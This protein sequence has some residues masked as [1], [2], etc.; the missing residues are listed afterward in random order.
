MSFYQKA[1]ELAGMGF[2]VFPL[3]SNSKLPLIKDF[4]N[5]ATRD[6][7][8]IKA[9]WVDPVLETERDYNVGIS[10]SKFGDN[11]TLIVIDVDNKGDKKGDDSLLA[12]EL[13]GKDV[14]PTLTQF[15]PTGGIHFIYRHFEPVKQGVNVLGN[16]IDIRAKGGFIVAAGSE[17]EA[18]KYKMMSGPV[19]QAPKWLVSACGKP[20]EKTTIDAEFTV[21]QEAAVGRAR[22]YLQNAAPVEQGQRNHS[23]YVMACKLKDFGVNHDKCLG[24]M[25]EHWKCEPPLDGEELE[26]VVSSAYTYG[27]EAVGS[28]APEAQFAPVLAAETL[29]AVQE[30]SYLERMNQE[31]ALV[32]MEG[33]HFIL[34]ETVDEKGRQKRS[35]LTEPTFKRKFSPN[36]VQGRGTYATEWLDWSRRREYRGVCF[37]PEREARNDYYN[38]WRGFTVTPLPYA[39]GDEVQ[40]KGFDSFI[41][42]ARNNICQ[43]DEALFQWLIGYF[44]HMV[45]RPYERPL[46][47]IVFRGGKG[48]GKNALVDRVGA[49]L[50]SGHYLVAHDGRYL[51]SNFNAHFDSCLCLV[52]DEAFWSG[53][54]NAEGKLKGLTTAPEIMIERK[55]KEPYMVDNLVRLVIIG[56]EEWLVPASTDERRYAVYDVGNGKKQNRK[57]F[58]EMRINLDEKGGNR[59]LLHYL[60]TFDLS[61]VDVNEAPKTQALL[62]QKMSSLEPF[63]EWWY[64]CLVAGRISNSD[65]AEGWTCDVSKSQF[66]DAF[67]RFCRERNIRSRLPD[68]ITIGRM[69][70][71]LAKATSTKARN[72]DGGSYYIYRLP[73][74]TEARSAWESHV[75]QEV[76][77]E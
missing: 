70:K 64:G 47:T 50:G 44:A 53:D 4:P 20:K 71:K 76:S 8:Q 52:L 33:S 35:F 5:R 59:I 2:H 40:R 28:A 43:G 73:D 66:R 31:F 41:D 65:F 61:T 72:E 60:Q 38:L 19:T 11:E 57:F 74:L 42:H 9:W 58:H 13:E 67:Y 56:N 29:P 23:A 39:D 17:V 6:P 14:P 34:H 48:V 15:T 3:R 12:L 46:T 18:G 10:T 75:G 69:L 68:E 27:T 62:D 32:Y 51:T 45:Q 1:L 49:L 30:E 25:S 55:G 36:S 63:E 7:E 37:A 24:L 16:G 21:D 54:K 22:E 77:W 26:H